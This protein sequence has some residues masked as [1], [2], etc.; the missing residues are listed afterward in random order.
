VGISREEAPELANAVAQLSEANAVELEVVQSGDNVLM[1]L[2]L[3]AMRLGIAIL[4]DY[5][6]SLL[7]K[8][9]TC[10][11]I[12]GNPMFDLV[13]A[14]RRDDHSPVRESFC[15]LVGEVIERTNL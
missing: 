14:F 13:M 10:R 3:V 1:I 5:V 15:E 11:P 2:S 4:P 6:E 12:E 8:N 9:V 7:I